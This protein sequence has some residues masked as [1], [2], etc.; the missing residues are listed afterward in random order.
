MGRGSGL[1]VVLNSTENTLQGQV[2]D[3]ISNS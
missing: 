1:P 3:V 2:M